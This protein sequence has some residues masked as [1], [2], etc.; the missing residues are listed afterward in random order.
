MASPSKA[1]RQQVARTLV[2]S[3]T[4]NTYGHGV[5]AL[6]ILEPILKDGRFRDIGISA[7][8]FAV[9]VALHILAYNITPAPAAGEDDDDDL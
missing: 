9:G 6:G 2:V 1:Y 4:L 5:I 8:L 7:L 3:K